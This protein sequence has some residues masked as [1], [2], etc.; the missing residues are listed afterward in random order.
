MMIRLIVH[1]K[2][3]PSLPEHHHFHHFLSTLNFI[4][5]YNRRDNFISK[6]VIMEP[7]STPCYMEKR[8]MPTQLNTLKVWSNIVNNQWMSDEVADLMAM[9]FRD[10]HLLL[11]KSSVFV[12]D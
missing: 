5:L 6:G 11:Q 8:G 2:G 4:S 9:K 1:R 10:R 7:L 3:T 12:Y